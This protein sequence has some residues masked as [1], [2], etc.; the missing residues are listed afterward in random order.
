MTVDRTT[1]GERLMM[2]RRRRGWSHAVVATGAG[3][4]E[5]RLWRI[6]AGDVWPEPTVL[7]ALCRVMGIDDE[8]IREE[9]DEWYHRLKGVG[10]IAGP[11]IF[12]LPTQFDP[13]LKIDGWVQ[14]PPGVRDLTPLPAPPPAPAIPWPAASG[15][16]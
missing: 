2:V 5:A 4:S 6:E 14:P 13:A 12:D 1:L 3:I 7:V 8:A 9:G 11:H 15:P 10:E 16:C